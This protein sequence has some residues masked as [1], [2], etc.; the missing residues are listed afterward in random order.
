MSKTMAMTGQV[1]AAKCRG[2]PIARRYGRRR[3]S[4]ADLLAECHGMWPWILR[5]SS[6]DDMRPLTVR[7]RRARN[8]TRRIDVMVPAAA[9]RLSPSRTVSW[10]DG[11]DEHQRMP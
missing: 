9:L 3:R 4:C 10:R 11:H 5:L 6:V 7:G 2:A 8:S 1:L